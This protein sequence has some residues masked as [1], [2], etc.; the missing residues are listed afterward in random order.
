MTSVPQRRLPP[1]SS[2][3]VICVRLGGSGHGARGS[4]CSPTWAYTSSMTTLRAPSR[5]ELEMQS[6]PVS[7]PPMTITF[8]PAALISLPGAG[9]RDA[10]PSWAAT[11]R[12]RW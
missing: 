6:M 9:A 10:R 3:Y 1:S 5:W 8:L 12:L 11:Q 4:P 7:P 2:A